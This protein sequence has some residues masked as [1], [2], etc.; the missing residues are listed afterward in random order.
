MSTVVLRTLGGALAC[1]VLTAYSCLGGEDSTPLARVVPYGGQ[2]AP[3]QARVVAEAAAWL[4][5]LERAADALAALPAVRLAGL[6]TL[7]LQALAAGMGMV[8][9]RV[10]L[11]VGEDASDG[12]RGATAVA[13]LADVDAGRASRL[14]A[15][16]NG[17]ERYEDIIAA[18][19][20]LIP[21]SMRLADTGRSL[22]VSDTPADDPVVV[23]LNRLADEVKAYSL[24]RDWLEQ[25]R[26]APEDFNLSA[27][28]VETGKAD[29]VGLK[30]V[31]K[32]G[33][34]QADKTVV[35]K[36]LAL[37]PDAL[38][39]R[40]ARA[41]LLLRED[42]FRAA[43]QAL[44]NLPPAPDSADAARDRADRRLLARALEARALAQL[45]SGRPTLAESDLDAALALAPE[46]GSLWLGRGA[47][48]Q[49]RESFEL[50]CGDYHQA[51]VR[52]LCRGLA[53]ARERGQCL[54]DGKER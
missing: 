4:A 53:A 24:Y 7:Q 14:L 12:E 21:E 43:A 18:L 5:G 39:L 15:D 22:P 17:R 13:R 54:D 2:V 31:N 49:M 27:Q 47:A 28:A 38:P 50:M 35:D 3:E 29:G 23:R 52:G 40:L 37:A 25:I 45:R 44:E 41:E 6:D 51:C 46:R 9:V 11:R 19:G 10:D 32:A 16:E 1:L 30:R 36:A 8:E 42:R 33:A 34:A 26:C 48:R 20:R